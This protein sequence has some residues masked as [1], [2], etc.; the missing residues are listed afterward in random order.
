[1][2]G[3][4]GEI[5]LRLSPPGYALLGHTATLQAHMGGAEANVAC[6][7]AAMGVPVRMFSRLPQNELG[8][9]ALAYLRQHSI[10][11]QHIAQGG[12]R[13]GTYYYQ[14]GAGPRPG[15]VVYDRQ[16][17]AFATWPTGITPWAECLGGLQLLHVT[18]ICPA[19][20]ALG[21]ALTREAVQAATVA[22]VPL[23]LDLNYRSTLWQYGTSPV[24]IMPELARH[25]TLLVA[26]QQSARVM[27]GIDVP[28]APGEPQAVYGHL[29]RQLAALAPRLQWLAFTHRTTTPQGAP[30]LTGFIYEVVTGSLTAGQTLPLEM[31]ERIG[32]GDAFTAG[33]IY[34]W[35]MQ[36]APGHALNLGLAA[37]SLKHTLPGDALTATVAEVEAVLGAPP[38]ARI[39]R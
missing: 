5:L 37:A 21:A 11:T 17:S 25:A 7:L 3:C 22:G 35:L 28:D 18:G 32:G 36:R 34:G 24:S 4:L 10:E 27:L 9:W 38:L 14:Q 2:V 12:T 1:M 19:V 20:S 29:A 6:A 31:I 15:K 26:D 16:E 30:A 23:S 33:L 8:H 13:L 39:H